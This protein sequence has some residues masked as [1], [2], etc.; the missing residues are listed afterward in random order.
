M[1]FSIGW[2]YTISLLLVLLALLSFKT[3]HQYNIGDENLLVNG[4][5][6]EGLSGWTLDT[7]SPDSILVSSGI[8]QIKSAN[9]NKSPKLW[10][11][12]PVSLLKSKVHVGGWV[13]TQQIIAGEDS[14]NKGRI[15]LVQLKD[16]IPIYSVP[17][18]LVSLDGT[19]SWQRYTNVFNV[20]PEASE[21]RIILQMS[22]SIGTFYCR[23]LQLNKD[24]VSS[25][26]APG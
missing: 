21:V 15:I 18:Q 14:W 13:R 22:R 25:C 20:L 17:H 24:P 12:F 11:S 8:V 26:R 1:R 9:K 10:Q 4:S 23:D 7:V 6:T 16:G 2:K 3:P 19:H 5:F